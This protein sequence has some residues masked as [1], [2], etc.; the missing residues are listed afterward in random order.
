MNLKETAAFAAEIIRECSDIK[1][2]IV[3]FGG[4]GTSTESGIPDFRSESGI[5][6]MG[7]YFGYPPEKILSLSFFKKYPALFYDYL[8]EFLLHPEAMPNEGHKALREMQKNWGLGEIVTQNIDGLHQKAGSD[9]VVEIHG[10]L[11]DYYCVDCA[12]YYGMDHIIDSKTP[13]ICT[14]CSG[15]VK[16][17]V[18][19]YEEALDTEKLERAR[20]AIAKACLTIVAGTSLNVFPAAGLLRV[21]S[22][23][24]IIINKESTRYDNAADLVVRYPF[25]Q[26]MAALLEELEGSK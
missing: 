16:P 3:F 13:H 15:I 17:D 14:K 24:L 7:K 22:G 10:T 5:F 2:S 23:K 18:V 6:N 12:R 20:K 26:F 1:G 21:K 19:L 25:S 9:K 11:Y 8:K 4:A